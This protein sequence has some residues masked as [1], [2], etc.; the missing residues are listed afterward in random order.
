MSRVSSIP[1]PLAQARGEA[2]RKRHGLIKN[3]VRMFQ[4]EFV[5]DTLDIL[6][7]FSA[8]ECSDAV[9]VC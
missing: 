1:L 3:M 2:I 6:E 4:L 5:I 7:R 9:E 8:F